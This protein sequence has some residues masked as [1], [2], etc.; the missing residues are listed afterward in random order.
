[1]ICLSCFLYNWEYHSAPRIPHFPELVA[2][3]V[4]PTGGVYTFWLKSFF[5]FHFVETL[6]SYLCSSPLLQN[7][8]AKIVQL[9][10]PLLG[11]LLENIQRVAGRDVLISCTAASSPVST[12][13]RPKWAPF[14]SP[15]PE[16]CLFVLLDLFP[17]TVLYLL[18]CCFLC[19]CIP[20]WHASCCAER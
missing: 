16:M 1:M 14:S 10:L 13:Q 7:Q 9:Y 6:S 20:L 18:C 8:Q 4:I 12:A 5:F 11:L 2:G 19:Y 15:H 3:R 17:V